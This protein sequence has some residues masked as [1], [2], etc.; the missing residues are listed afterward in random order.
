[1][2]CEWMSREIIFDPFNAVSALH[3]NAHYFAHFTI[4]A[5]WLAAPVRCCLAALL[6]AAYC[7]LCDDEMEMSEQT[8]QFPFE[9]A[10]TAKTYAL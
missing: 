10:L 9:L 7:N 3:A 4:R 5:V 1:M 6:L 2:L 8:S